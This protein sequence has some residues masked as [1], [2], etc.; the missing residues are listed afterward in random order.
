[1]CKSASPCPLIIQKW[2]LTWP[3][4]TLPIYPLLTC[5]ELS[6][7]ALSFF[8]SSFLRVHCSWHSH[9]PWSIVS[10]PM[11]HWQKAS[12]T[13]FLLCKW[14]REDP[15]VHRG[16]P[17]VPRSKPSVLSNRSNGPSRCHSIFPAIL[18]AVK[19]LR[20][21]E[22]QTC[23]Q[24]SVQLGL[25]TKFQ[26]SIPHLPVHQMRWDHH[27]GYIISSSLRYLRDLLVRNS[28]SFGR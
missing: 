19:S 11:P 6:P 22:C 12:W 1:M 8:C 20:E 5:R 13:T 26:R 3:Y 10:Y 25:K 18:S 4:C 15:F 17:S 9:S 27:Q 21:C 16:K 23:S 28:M 2:A 24:C 14:A 7:A